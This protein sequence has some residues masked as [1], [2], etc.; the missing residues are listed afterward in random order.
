[1]TKTW[2]KIRDRAR[3]RFS[4]FPVASVALYGPDDRIATKVAIAILPFEGGEVQ[5]LERW[6]A[7][8][9]DVRDDEGIAVAALAFIRTHGA[10]S[11]G[12]IDQ[13]IGCPH[14]EGI[15][16][17]LGTSCPRCPFWEG[18]DRWAGLPVED[19]EAALPASRGTRPTIVADLRHFLDEDGNLPDELPAPALNLALHL[20]AIVAWMTAVVAEEEVEVTNVVCRRRPRGRRC[21]GQILARFLPSDDRIEWACPACDDNGLIDGWV[22]SPWD[23]SGLTAFDRGLPN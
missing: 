4:G 2:R 23:R 18:R 9:G 1:M 3:R 10:R 7:P 16:Y 6:L 21:R 14:E 5:R 13:I 11:I 20:G 19:V 17:P 8:S 15:D 22:G 12:M